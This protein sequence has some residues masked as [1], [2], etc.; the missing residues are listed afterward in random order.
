ML[1]FPYIKSTYELISHVKTESILIEKF[2]KG[3]ITKVMKMNKHSIFLF[4][5]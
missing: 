2:R 4:E 5:K 3:Q 1:S